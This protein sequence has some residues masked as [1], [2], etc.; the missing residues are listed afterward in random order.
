MRA[1]LPPQP[2]TTYIGASLDTLEVRWFG[3]GEASPEVLERFTRNG[4][5]GDPEHRVDRYVLDGR[6]DVG[7]KYRELDVLETKVLDSVEGHLTTSWGPPAPLEVWRKWETAGSPRGAL[8]D[9]DKHL[10]T[11]TF[12]MAPAT[13][14]RVT[15]EVEIASLAIRDRAY[16]TL[17]FEASGDANWREELIRRSV[18]NVTAD[19]TM[20][21]L[22]QGSLTI[23]ASYP[24]WLACHVD[25]LVGAREVGSG[26]SIA[27]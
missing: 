20:R 9:I 6:A 24:E 21:S 8:V 1:D 25:V 16:W 15:C 27:S 26:S 2:S 12:V 11:R 7:I 14:V 23:S 5:L 17:A 10:V 19:E 18:E 22:L 13:G 3:T 4:Q